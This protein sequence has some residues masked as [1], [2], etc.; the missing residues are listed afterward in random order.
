MQ[1]FEVWR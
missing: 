1:D